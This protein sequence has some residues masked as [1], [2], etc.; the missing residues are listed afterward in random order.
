MNIYEPQKA[1]IPYQ[2]SHTELF[3][4]FQTFAEGFIFFVFF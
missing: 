4:S 1:H 2:Q 3:N